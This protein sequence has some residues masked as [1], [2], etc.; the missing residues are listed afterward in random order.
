MT[1]LIA[2][3]ILAATLGALL[4]GGTWVLVIAG[5]ESNG[6]L[7]A[8]SICMAL[9]GRTSPYNVYS[10]EYGDDNHVKE[11]AGDYHWHRRGEMF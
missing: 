1:E 4:A 6:K 7:A 3:I 10:W 5:K 9:T 2:P 11:R 8:R